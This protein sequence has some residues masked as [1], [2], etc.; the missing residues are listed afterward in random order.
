M[1]TIHCLLF[2]VRC[3]NSAVATS[4]RYTLVLAGR[5]QVD[6]QKLKFRM[7]R[8]FSNKQKKKLLLGSIF[9]EV[10]FVCDGTRWLGE[11]SSIVF[12]QN[13]RCLKLCNI[14]LKRRVHDRKRFTLT[15]Q[16]GSCKYQKIFIG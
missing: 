4:S 13:H 12:E 6:H 1:T 10:G 9:H 5:L 11:A 2:E 16:S 8:F 7:D 3:R 14:R 15:L